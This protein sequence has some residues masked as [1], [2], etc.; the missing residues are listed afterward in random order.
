MD[1]FTRFLFWLRHV[2]LVLRRVFLVLLLLYLFFAT[3]VDALRFW[4]R[5]EQV[6]MTFLG[7]ENITYSN[8]IA[9]SPNTVRL[10]NCA[11]EWRGQTVEKLADREFSFRVIGVE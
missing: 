9:D 10:E 1:V 8:E 7:Y 6:E 11:F 2:L 4:M 3:T 5:S